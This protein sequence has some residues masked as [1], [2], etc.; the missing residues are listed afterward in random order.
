MDEYEDERRVSKGMMGIGFFVIDLF[1]KFMI[2]FIDR[3]KFI[4]KR[5][6]CLITYC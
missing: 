6:D 5:I 1:G 3:N 2:S 4:D